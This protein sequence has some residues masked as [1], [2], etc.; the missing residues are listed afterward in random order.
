M[1]LNKAIQY[2]SWICGGGQRPISVAA[3]EVVGI[4]QQKQGTTEIDVDEG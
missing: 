1:K 3:A 2:C 4:G